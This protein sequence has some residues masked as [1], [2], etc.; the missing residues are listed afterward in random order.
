MERIDIALSPLVRPANINR[1]TVIGIDRDG[2][3]RSD[4]LLPQ[5]WSV[6]PRDGNTL[7][8]QPPRQFIRW[9]FQRLK[10]KRTRC[11]CIIA[12]HDDV[13]RC[14]CAI[15]FSPAKQPRADRILPPAPP[16]TPPP[17]SPS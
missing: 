4:A 16:P 6:R 2:K 13:A 7:Y 8:H 10:W 9:V 15:Q 17:T 5:G 3:R 1:G 12:D 11:S 14:D